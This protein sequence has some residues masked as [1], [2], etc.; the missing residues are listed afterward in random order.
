MPHFVLCVLF[1]V[2]V[3][4]HYYEHS[5]RYGSEKSLVMEPHINIIDSARLVSVKQNDSEKAD[6]ILRQLPQEKENLFDH[7]AHTFGRKTPNI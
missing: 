5:Q 2:F 1:R 4:V 7:H 3:A 6:N